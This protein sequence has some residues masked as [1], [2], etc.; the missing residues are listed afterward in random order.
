AV[1]EQ[2]PPLL[3]PKGARTARDPRRSPPRWEA[4]FAGRRQTQ[5]AREAQGSVRP[6]WRPGPLG[7]AHVLC[8]RSPSLLVKGTELVKASEPVRRV[9]RPQDLVVSEFM[10]IDGHDVQRPILRGQADEVA[11]LCAGQLRTNDHLVALLQDLF[12]PHPQVWK[13]VVS[14]TIRCFI[15]SRPGGGPAAAGMSTRPSRA[16]RSTT[17]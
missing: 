8:T 14:C 9:P 17:A 6:N 2:H 4:A 10:D 15:P 7:I 12:V 3:N 13:L 11:S 1:R 5:T 16:S